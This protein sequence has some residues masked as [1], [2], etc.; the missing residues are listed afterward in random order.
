M[1]NTYWRG[2]LQLIVVVAACSYC[3]GCG[4][5]N[6]PPS[7]HSPFTSSVSSTANPLVANY[8]VSAETGGTARI[9]FGTDISYGLQTSWYSVPPNGDGVA[10]L[11]AGMKA[12]TTYHMRAEVVSDKTTW[13]D[14]DRLFTTGSLPSQ[15]FPSLAISRPTEAALAEGENPGV[16]LINLT[17][18]VANLIEAI[19]ADRD[20]NVVWYYDVGAEQANLPYPIKLLPNGHMLINIQNGATGVTRLREIDLAGRTIREMDVATLQQK[21]QARGQ[22]LDDLAFHHDFLY[23]SNGHLVVLGSASR[24]FSDLPGYPGVTKVTGDLLVDLDQN[25]NPVWLWNAF[26]HLDVTRH[27]MGLPD[28]THSNAVVYLPNDGNLLLSMR[29]QS[30]ILKIDYSDG[31]G[32]GAVLWRLGQDG[33]FALA[34]GDP[35]QWFYGQHFPSLVTMDGSSLSMAVFDNGN[36]R[37]LDN[38]G[39]ECGRPGPACYSRATIFQVDESARLA[40]LVWQESPGIYSLWGGSISQLPNGNVEFAMSAPFPTISGSR[41][42]EVTHTDTPQIVWQMDIEKGHAYRAYR[43]PSLYPGVSWK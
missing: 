16:E 4:S 35:S 29:N 7:S 23:L 22:T 17:E 41:V 10:I 28:W 12:S 25:W 30:W 43:I 27:L 5:V 24:N 11:V 9:E 42:L 31:T 37:I 21:L 2:L 34:S 14:E 38:H 32:S 18:P 36:L 40:R 6:D 8:F 33:D 26:D 19:V 20:G 15:Q 1:T 3:L 13:F 39:D